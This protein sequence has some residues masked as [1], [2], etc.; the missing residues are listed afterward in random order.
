MFSSVRWPLGL[1][2]FLLTL[3]SVAL[4]EISLF[5]TVRTA[6]LES[7]QD[8]LAQDCRFIANLMRRHMDEVALTPE[9][10]KRI[11]DEM[12]RLS[13]D[14]SGWLAVVNWKG[15]VLE[16]TA[17]RS[18]QLVGH[19]PEVM[20]ALHGQPQMAIRPFEGQESE[21]PLDLESMSDPTMYVAVPMLAQGKVTGA[22]YGARSLGQL[23]LTLLALRQRL[24]QAALISLGLSLLASLLLARWLSQPL[25]QLSLHAR[26]FG[27]GHLEERAN[28]KGR[29]E[30][31]GLARTFNSMAANLQQHQE[32]LLRFVS[33]ASHELKTPV[34][35]LQS[36]LE[37]LQEGAWEQPEL[38]QRFVQHMQRDLDRMQKLVK[39][40]LD[41]HRVQHTPLD[42]QDYDPMPLLGQL[43]QDYQATL[44][45]QTGPLRVHP[46]RLEQ[47]LTNLLDNA[48][49]ALREVP[50]PCLELVC[51]PQRIE[52]RDNGVGLTPQDQS[53]VFERFFRVD[54]ARTRQD[55]G[56]G[57]GLAICESLM[58]AM[59]GRISVSSPGLG[60]GTTFVLEWKPA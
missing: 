31:A 21:N 56:S 41:L 47:V 59:G 51:S 24:Y 15:Q 1:A 13:L 16:D 11:T 19:R 14:M 22:I 18:G 45:G 46:D 50:N 54:S 2:F 36:L 7:V 44:R 6:Y 28:L 49:R 60:Q 26:R 58:E 10:R 33:D 12:H 37:A 17:H 23:Q 48:S 25:R 8:G 30:I 53:R 29:D 27:E 5:R 39:D 55:G 52:V 4:S 43:C 40:L 38:R 32:S 57:L 9:A 35:S 20:A 42:L 3:C 34:A